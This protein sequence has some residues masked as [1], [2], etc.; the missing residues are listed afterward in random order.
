VGD[1]DKSR[2]MLDVLCVW[3]TMQAASDELHFTR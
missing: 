3:S 1:S 2:L